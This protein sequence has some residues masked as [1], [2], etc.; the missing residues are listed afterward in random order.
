MRHQHFEFINAEMVANAPQ[1]VP[2]RVACAR[3][4][5]HELRA[6]DPKAST[7]LA[8]RDLVTG[9]KTQIGHEIGHHIFF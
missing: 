3:Q 5:L 6:V 4:V 8:D 9:R 2:G 7:H 1:V